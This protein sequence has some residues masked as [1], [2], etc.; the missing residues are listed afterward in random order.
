MP[1]KRG[2]NSSVAAPPSKTVVEITFTDEQRRTLEAASGLK[3][4]TGMK[5]VDLDTNARA[6]LQ[7]GL[8]R[9]TV[10]VMCW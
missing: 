7:P 10:A 3:G 1:D 2:T 5:L 8:V 9:A 4:L 6:K